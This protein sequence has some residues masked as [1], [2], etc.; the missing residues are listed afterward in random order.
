MKKEV[1]FKPCVRLLET[2]DRFHFFVNE[3]RN[4]IRYRHNIP[5]KKIQH[6]SSGN[7]V[8]H[9]KNYYNS[10]SATLEMIID[11]DIQ[12][13]VF[14]DLVEDEVRYLVE[15]FRVMMDKS[16]FRSRLS[17]EAIR[18]NYFK[19]MVHYHQNPKSRSF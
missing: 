5:Y 9:A 6:G 15:Y 3:V 19:K 7:L 14:I 4:F 13:S 8:M 1:Y 17:N 16:S 18:E 2:F 10:K 11:H 12:F